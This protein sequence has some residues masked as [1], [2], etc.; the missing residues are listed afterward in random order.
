MDSYDARAIESYWQKR[1]ADDGL[2]EYDVSSSPEETYYNLVEFPYPSAEGLHIGSV[3]TYAGADTFGRYQAMGGKKVFQPMG[4]DSFG[5]NA[6]NF[7][8]KKREHPARLI[9]RTIP[10]FRRQLKRMGAGWDW[11]REV[12]TSDPR[13]YRW[14]QWIFLRLFEAGLAYQASAPVVWCPSCET[15]LAFEQT[16]DDRCERC[17]SPTES[18]VMRQWFLRM[19]AYAEELH[20]AAIK[21]DW[22]DWARNMQV[23]WIGRSVLPDGSVTYRLRDWLISRQRYWGPPIPIVHC[24]ACGPMPVPDSELP[25]RLPHIEDFQK[26]LASDKEFMVAKCPSCGV[27]GVRESD[28]SDTF[29]DSCWYFLRYSSSDRDDVG[30][31]N[32]RVDRIMPID[33][34]EGGREHICRHHLYARFISFALN[35]LG[36]TTVRE[37]FSSFS[38]HGLI[39]HRGTKMS[40][41]RGNVIGPDKLMDEVGADVLR[42]ALLFTG[43]WEASG[44]FSFGHIETMKRFLSRV[45]RVVLD[46]SDAGARPALASTVEKVSRDVERSKFNTALATLMTSIRKVVTPDERR[47]FVLL[48]APFAPHFA[49]ELWSRLG[50]PYSVHRQPWPARGPIR[51]TDQVEI[52]IQVDGK[53][54]QTIVLPRGIAEAEVLTAARQLHA[55][56]VLRVVFIP[57]RLLNL[58]TVDS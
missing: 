37:P 38:F 34:Y 30:W 23:K 58:V 41:S 1:W 27:E 45:S 48:L 39:T 44:D 55:G 24:K 2:Y 28:V 54:R 36:L 33:R 5:I 46:G 4:F 21:S 35:D 9:E 29:F 19:A 10:N 8:I 31:V 25:V 40:K 18:R 14:T 43:P 16:D 42:M 53:F 57:D 32:E 11:S 26:G 3:R 50:E 49:E 47:T 52:I 20:Q 17:L 15:V 6:E 13:Y 12:V 7:A 22:P 51:L 56:K